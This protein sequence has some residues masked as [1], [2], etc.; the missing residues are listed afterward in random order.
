MQRAPH[1]SILLATWHPRK[2]DVHRK[3]GRENGK[4]HL[5]YII[6]I[7]HFLQKKFILH[8]SMYK[9][10]RGSLVSTSNVLHCTPKKLSTTHPVAAVT[11]QKKK[12]SATQHRSRTTPS[13]ERPCSLTR[14]ACCVR[15]Y[16]VY[17]SSSSS[18]DRYSRGQLLA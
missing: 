8:Q 12:Q 15:A 11:V 14:G 13:T 9:C 5:S 7:L 1:L 18:S 17:S 10:I 3:R 2:L 6:Y 4:A 16:M